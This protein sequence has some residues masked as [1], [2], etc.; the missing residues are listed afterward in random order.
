MVE[1]I[2]LLY[3]E[4]CYRG[5]CYKSA[6]LYSLIFGTYFLASIQIGSG[7]SLVIDKIFLSLSFSLD[8]NFSSAI[9]IEHV[10]MCHMPLSLFFGVLLR[11]LCCRG[12]AN[13]Q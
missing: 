5:V 7:N 2:A 1:I 3:Q 8:S 12:S 6:P 13:Q 4:L 9:R 11:L 10:L